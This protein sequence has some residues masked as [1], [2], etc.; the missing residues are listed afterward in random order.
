M[1]FLVKLGTPQGRT[2]LDARRVLDL[3]CWA[4]R[5]VLSKG[6][7][8]QSVKSPWVA[9]FDQF[10]GS[11]KGSAIVAAPYI[12]RE[13][14][15]RLVSKLGA[16]R[17]SVR[18]ELL[19]NLSSDSAVGGSLD[20]GALAWLCEKAPNTT[21]R[22]LRY[23]HAKAYVADDHLA[24]VTSSNLT[25]GGLHRNHELGVAITAPEA[26]RDIATD[27]TEYG[28]LGVL[29]PGDDLATL[30][31]IA[32]QARERRSAVQAASSGD[33][34]NGPD[35]IARTID[36]RL[37]ELRTAG[38]E[39]RSDPRGS[40]TGQFADAVRYVLR[41]YG[42]LPTS[43]IGPLVRTLKPELCDDEVDRVINGQSFGK[44]WKHDIRN[45]QQQLKKDGIIALE[46][47]KWRLV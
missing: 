47:R 23:L 19:T 8:M 36:E 5:C 21:V 41:R 11:I 6:D 32:Q 44:R 12:T 38:E 17:R 7:A 45:A 18:L 43:E 24:I 13:P 33:S 4:N 39:F 16:R 42:P 46:N 30:G 35:E 28:E 1:I 20:V 34:K 3:M 25:N 2:E 15:E 26:V 40:I 37:I 22:H 29:V 9:T 31:D 10:A 14:V 27:L